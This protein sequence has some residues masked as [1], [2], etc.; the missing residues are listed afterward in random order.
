MLEIS[1]TLAAIVSFVLAVLAA[2]EDTRD[3]QDWVRHRPL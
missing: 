2:G 3:G 1:V